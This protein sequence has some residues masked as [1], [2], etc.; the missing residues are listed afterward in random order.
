[1]ADLSA[2]SNA[3]FDTTLW[4]NNSFRDRPDEEAVESYL[5]SLAMKLHIISQDYTDQLETGM[6]EAM[7]RMP[8][9][10]SDVARI[11]ETLKNIE[12]EMQSLAMQL[13]TF[14]Q[15]NVTGVEDLSRLDTLKSNMEKCKATLEEH[16][17]WSQVVREAKNFLESGGRLSDSADRI[18]TM[19]KS[20][21][22]LQNLP[23]HEERKETCE[24]L[25]DA[26]L[27]ALRPKVRKDI[28]SS[29][30]SPLH[31]YL[32]VYEKLGKKIELEEEYVRARPERLK[33]VWDKF[34][35]TPTAQ[36]APW[37]ALFLGKVAG[38]LSDESS[39]AS[40]LFGLD[41]AP[42]V[43]CSL[44]HHALNPL[45]VPMVNKISIYKIVQYFYIGFDRMNLLPFSIKMTS[46]VL[47]ATSMTKLFQAERL[48]SLSEGSPVPI[49]EIYSVT[50]EF[51]RRVGIHLEGCSSQQIF[52]ALT[53]LFAGFTKYFETYGAKEGQFLE[54]QLLSALS[55]VS[56]EAE[57]AAVT[58]D[59]DSN[60]DIS[61][62]DIDAFLD[63]LVRSL[64]LLFYNECF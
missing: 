36:F 10:L 52:T 22:I 2:F 64:T 19:Y 41:R 24:S 37:L 8:R 33:G 50:D 62:G 7:T 57:K 27:A 23:G 11:E 20:L 15:R 32:Y 46:S 47:N 53:S 26:L 28:V 40:A 34:S 38:L 54:I 5:A 43:L 31:E 21:D 1:M 29:D 14:D 39:H 6:V 13:R 45:A 17:R 63:P 44:L 12:G 18:E 49:A 42:D 61:E 30:L 48:S 51:A 60:L 58:G 3:Q 35:V 25:S 4:I 16:A 55:S 56:F 9:V 59:G